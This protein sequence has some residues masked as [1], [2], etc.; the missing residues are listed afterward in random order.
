M[1][2]YAICG[3]F[4]RIDKQQMEKNHS[5]NFKFVFTAKFLPQFLGKKVQIQNTEMTMKQLII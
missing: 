4:S 3:I 5:G 1:Y 2:L